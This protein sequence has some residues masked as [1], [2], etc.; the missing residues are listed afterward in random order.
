MEFTEREKSLLIALGNP[1]SNNHSNKHIGWLLGLT[2]GTIKKN[3]NQITFKYGFDRAKSTI[4]G[5]ILWMEK[6]GDDKQKTQ[7]EEFRKR[8]ETAFGRVSAEAP[9]TQGIFV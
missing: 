7:V 6:Y 4:V 2:E 3:F 5:F 1:E 9:E 8:S